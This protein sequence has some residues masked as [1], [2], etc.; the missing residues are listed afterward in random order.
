MNDLLISVI[1]PIY[2]VEDYVEKCLKSLLS[3]TYGNFEVLAINDGSTDNSGKIVKRLASY[4]KRIVY[5]EKPN[6]GLSD[7]RN[8]GI[9]ASKGE[10]ITFIDS[11]DYVDIDYLSNLYAPFKSNKQIDV[12]A[13]SLRPVNANNE[14]LKHR[15]YKQALYSG[16]D[17]LKEVLYSRNLECYS[18]GKIFRRELFDNILFTK[19]RLFEDIDIIYKLLLNAKLVQVL[20]YEGYN[21]LQRSG[22]ITSS[23]F[24][25]KQ[26]IL[27]EIMNEMKEFVQLEKPCLLPAVYRRIS[28]S[29]IWLISKISISGTTNDT[30]LKLL[31]DKLDKISMIVLKDKESSLIDKLKIVLLK[32]L[33]PERFARIYYRI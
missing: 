23:S 26:M 15:A 1:V 32:I 17:A 20:E 3:Q 21:Y 13:C 33:G 2:N 30:N 4:D 24:N 27:L 6:G 12:V 14:I 10:L 25:Q 5:I 29:Y 19:G 22:T 11:D 9:K 31:I 7:A 16:V 8:T 28:F 18:C